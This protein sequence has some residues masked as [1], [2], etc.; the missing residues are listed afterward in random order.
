MWLMCVFQSVVPYNL[1]LYPF[2]SLLFMFLRS[3]MPQAGRYVHRKCSCLA[4]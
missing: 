3:E 2:T 1:F 4:E